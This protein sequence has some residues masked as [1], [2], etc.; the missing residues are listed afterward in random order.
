MLPGFL[1]HSRVEKQADD[2]AT[3]LSM[4]H[5]EPDILNTINTMGQKC[6]HCNVYTPSFHKHRTLKGI[7]VNS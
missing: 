5:K 7:Y 2:P 4:S 3:N 6:P 1:S